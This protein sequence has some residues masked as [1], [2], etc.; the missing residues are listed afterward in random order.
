MST[1]PEF[2][3]QFVEKMIEEYGIHYTVGWLKSAYI[4]RTPFEIEDDLINES[5]KKMVEESKEPK[6]D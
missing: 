2:R 4:S 3:K 5:M 6:N 1:T